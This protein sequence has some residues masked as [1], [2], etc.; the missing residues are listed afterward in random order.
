MEGDADRLFSNLLRKVTG[1]HYPLSPYE[2][3]AMYKVLHDTF[4]PRGP[5]WAL[6]GTVAGVFY[7]SSQIPLARRT[8][9]RRW[10]T[11]MVWGAYSYEFSWTWRDPNPSAAYFNDL[12]SSCG[13][14]RDMAVY[15]GHPYRGD[16]RSLWIR[17][18][19]FLTLDRTF[20]AMFT[21]GFGVDPR[22]AERRKH[23]TLW[24]SLMG[25]RLQSHPDA[26]IRF[27][28]RYKRAWLAD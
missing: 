14:V 18:V 7:Y 26:Y 8:R 4:N 9:V 27:Y 20:D 24:V 12:R 11:L 21:S 6:G 22:R 25:D 3:A 23:E 16:R 13:G 10:L 2:F 19:D 28:W 17:I 1:E 5:L 15:P